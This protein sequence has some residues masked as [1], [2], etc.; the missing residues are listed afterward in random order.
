MKHAYAA[1]KAYAG[2]TLAEFD[3]YVK[4]SVQ[5]YCPEFS[6]RSMS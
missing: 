2:M 4:A 6:Q 1:A 5:G 3:A